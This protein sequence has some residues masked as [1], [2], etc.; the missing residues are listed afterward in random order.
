MF[1]P[2]STFL[3]A[4]ASASLLALTACSSGP[5]ETSPG[6]YLPDDA[7]TGALDAVPTGLNVADTDDLR[8][9]KSVAAN[10]RGPEQ[11]T[12]TVV[13]DADTLA[14]LL[15]SNTI[16]QPDFDSRN[17]IVLA[18]GTQPATG[19]GIEITGLQHVA[20]DGA[21]VVYV[22]ASATEPGT[23]SQAVE[24]RPYAAVEVEA[25]PEDVLLR[26]DIN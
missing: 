7:D 4:A 5:A 14:E 3:L 21:D 11:Y 19:Y 17:V 20:T 15:P 23:D 1:R 25:L 22:E 18:M 24:T 13:R 26:S 2:A 16:L 8:I 9:L 6:D 10:D 12:L